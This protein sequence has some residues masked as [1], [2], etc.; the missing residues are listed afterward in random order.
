MPRSGT[1]GSQSS[2]VFVVEEPPMLWSSVAVPAAAPNSA[3]GLAF[4]PQ[5]LPGM[6][7]V[8]VTH[9]LLSR[10]PVVGIQ[11]ASARAHSGAGTPS[12]MLLCAHVHIHK[13]DSEKRNH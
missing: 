8:W 4:F 5:P 12:D 13:M 2:P 11:C 10:C 6:P 1:A 7:V 9:E 3:G